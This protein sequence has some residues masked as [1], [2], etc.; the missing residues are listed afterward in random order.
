MVG[1][2]LGKLGYLVTLKSQPEA[3]AKL[4]TSI[5]SLHIQLHEHDIA[6]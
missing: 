4:L 6:I 1:Q 3:I 2:L 5:F